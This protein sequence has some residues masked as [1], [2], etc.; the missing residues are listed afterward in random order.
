MPRYRNIVGFPGYRVGD[1]GSVWCRLPK[2]GRAQ[3]DK[4][5][6]WRP[7]SVGT[8]PQGVCQVGLNRDGRHHTKS[9]GPLVLTAFVGPKPPGMQCRHLDDVQAHNALANLKWGTP[10]ENAADRDRNGR[11]QRGDTHSSA[12]LTAAIVKRLRAAPKSVSTS[13]LIRKLGLSIHHS[14]VSLARR[15]LTWKHVKR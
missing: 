9:L 6:P 12:V 10:K 3:R 1:D 13:E 2:Y 7:V 5:W 11:T 15:G 4:R 14:T 8:N